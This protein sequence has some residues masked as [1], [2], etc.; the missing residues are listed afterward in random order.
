MRTPY[1]IQ[2]GNQY[3]F[4]IRLPAD[5]QEHFSCTHLKKS[6]KTRDRRQAATKSRLFSSG[7]ERA[8]FMIRSGLLTPQMISKI[9][10]EVKEGM[11]E[12]HRK[13][14]RKLGVNRAEQFRANVEHLKRKIQERDFTSISEDATLQLECRGMDA[15]PG[16]REF[17]ELC[18]GLLQTKK[19]VFEVMAE[20]EDGNYN[21]RYDNGLTPR[22]LE[23]KYR[24]S[25]LIAD[26]TEHS[27]GGVRFQQRRRDNFKKIL[28]VIG[29]LFTRDISKDVV[30]HLHNELSQYPTNRFKNPFAGKTLAECRLL[31]Q[32]QIAK[33]ITQ[34]DTWVDVKSLLQYGIEN[35]KYKIVR[36][37]SKDGIFKSK[38]GK[39][40]NVTKRA[41]YGQ[42]DLIS[43][44]KGLAQ[45]IYVKQP[46]R[47]WIPLVGLFQGMRQNEIC[48]LYLDDVFA[49]PATGIQ[50][51]RIT[52]NPGRNQKLDEPNLKSVKNDSSRR[53][54]PIHPELIK[55]G[56][57]DYIESRRKL[58]HTRLWEKLQTPAVD[59]YDNAGNYSHYVSKWYCS[60]F[61]K[62]HIKNEPE[63]KPFHSLRHTFINWHFQNI[64]SN[65]MDFS[66]VKGLVGHIDSMEQKLIGKLLDAESWTTYSQE[67]NVSRLYDALCLFKPNVDLGLL[68]RRK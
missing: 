42:D 47:Y 11:L 54:I 14:G 23:H 48:Q 61:R 31:P 19:R 2:R 4:Q 59:Y 36:N 44:F 50:C 55:L 21:N 25:E 3:Y 65:D 67:L 27:G 38:K 20:R 13:H 53:T 7:I 39:G 16:S 1:L 40:G 51:I 52:D 6:L 35:E 63:L 41:V 28:D 60:T 37:F 8:F 34:R 24:L 68:K 62:N 5:V 33:P 66:A 9:V 10:T 29:D 15:D 45:E 17:L 58:K 46:H 56:F 57:L 26:Y 22:V 12:M 32:F 43:L 18:D 64:K 30:Q 49:D